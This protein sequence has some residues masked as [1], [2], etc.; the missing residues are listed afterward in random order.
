MYQYKEL[1]IKTFSG[2]E[3]VLSDELSNLDIQILHTGPR[4]V[5]V[6]ATRLQMLLCNFHLRT[7]L[8]V[9]LPLKSFHISSVN[10]FYKEI[11]SINW[12]DWFSSDESIYIDVTGASPVFQNTFFAA[13]KAKDA[14]V[15]RFRAIEGRRP[16]VDKENPD[17]RIDIHLHGETI[18]V[19]M[20][21][22]G[23]SLNRR[24]YR[25]CAAKAPINEVLAAGIIRL[26]GW[27]GQMP[28]YDPM[29]GS[30]TFAIEAAMLAEN[31][32]AGFYR[33]DYSFMHW[34]DFDNSEWEK[35][36]T[37]YRDISA[38]SRP[39]ILASDIQGSIVRCA[40][41]NIKQAGLGKT[42]RLFRSDF[43]TSGEN[44]SQGLILMNPPYG[45]RIK[46]NDILDFYKCIGTKLKHS[47]AGCRAAIISSNVDAL[48]MLG[49]KPS[50]K[51]TLYNGP[52]ES[53]LL[54]FDL[55]QG[56]RKDYRGN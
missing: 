23:H 37:E 5:K 36:K 12:D 9:L 32:P 43:F 21:S 20:D 29:C 18:E 41:D 11:Y 27:H 31:I 15:D 1:V 33:R 44:F 56:K 34:R 19:N 17:I 8:R 46:D 47:F 24:G 49:L 28:L 14:I 2:L 45:E 51:F 55:F 3:G 54:I 53:K 22:S 16:N 48:K 4:F 39:V 30:G 40:S 10:D 50:E 7:A 13:Q 25:I 38:T 52:L 26:S 6:E 42:I 35:I